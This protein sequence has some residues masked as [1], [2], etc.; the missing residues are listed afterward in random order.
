M[1][2]FGGHTVRLA[3]EVESAFKRSELPFSTLV[4]R[5]MAEFFNVKLEKDQKAL[6][7][8]MMIKQRTQQGGE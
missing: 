7:M 8:E 2:T 4:N 5:L 6:R 3:P 1:A